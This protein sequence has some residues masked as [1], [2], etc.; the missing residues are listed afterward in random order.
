M[1]RR[2]SIVVF[3]LLAVLGGCHKSAPKN[4]QR[5]ASGEVLQGTISDDMLP[6][7]QLSSQPPLLQPS[8][9]PTTPEAAADQGTSETT[10]NAASAPTDASSATSAAAPAAASSSTP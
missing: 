8:K 7:A 10:D 1:I 9:Q 3:A 5:S 6:L 4:D 2:Y